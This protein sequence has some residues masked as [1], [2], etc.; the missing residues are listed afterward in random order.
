MTGRIDG[1]GHGTKGLVLASVFDKLGIQK[2]GRS[3]VRCGYSIAATE[4]TERAL[5][6][7]GIKP[8]PA[9][10]ISRN[11]EGFDDCI[12]TISFRI[13]AGILHNRLSPNHRRAAAELGIPSIDMV[14]CNF[15]PIH[16]VIKCPDRDFNMAN[17]D[18][19]GPLMVRAAAANFRQV[20]VVVDPGD[21]DEVASSVGSGNVTYQLRRKLAERA[22]AYTCAYD[23]MLL[24]CL[25]GIAG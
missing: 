22:F 21:Y 10:T 3:L 7:V 24:K 1:A 4:G 8:I 6:D 18:V 25:R 20:L 23:R 15:P 16:Q 11:P 19:G 17:I 12:Q 5:K 13:E 2:L 9:R 14:I